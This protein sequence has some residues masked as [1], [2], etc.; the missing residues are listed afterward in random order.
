MDLFMECCW[1][2]QQHQGPCSNQRGFTLRV[3]RAW[4]LH[5]SPLH[6]VVKQS[7][8]S[9]MISAVAVGSYHFHYVGLE[10][11]WWMEVLPNHVACLGKMIIILG[12]NSTYGFPYFF[13]QILM[14][15]SD[16]AVRRGEGMISI[17]K[18]LKDS[19]AV[20]PQSFLFGEPFCGTFIDSE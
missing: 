5:F 2:V 8:L 9:V 19:C 13:K 16:S 17:M 7:A 18:S 14:I 6:P 15:Y 12:R 4:N 10:E 20:S 11:M 3:L 1:K